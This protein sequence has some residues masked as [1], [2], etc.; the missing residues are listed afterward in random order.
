MLRRLPLHPD[1]G[2]GPRRFGASATLKFGN[3]KVKAARRSRGG[4]IGGGV[5][6]LERRGTASYRGKFN[7]V[8]VGFNLP[9]H[10]TILSAERQETLSMN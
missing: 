1:A 3:Q 10:A 2:A 8:H 7:I 4:E 9:A 6:A 5:A